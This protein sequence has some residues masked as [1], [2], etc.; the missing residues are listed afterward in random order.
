MVGKINFSAHFSGL[1]Q[2]PDSQQKPHLVG[3]KKTLYPTYCGC[4]K[5]FQKSYASDIP[6]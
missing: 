2:P 6:K 5:I 1:R 4:K 3:V